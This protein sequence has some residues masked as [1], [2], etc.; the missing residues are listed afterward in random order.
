MPWRKFGVCRGL[1]PAL[2]RHNFKNLGTYSLSGGPEY[3]LV[4]A[5]YFHF[6]LSSLRHFQ[7]PPDRLVKIRLSRA[8]RQGNKLRTDGLIRN[9]F[10]FCE[11]H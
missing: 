6:I 11:F 2:K 5:E 7:R 3:S 8:V 1:L 10:R 9:F 4:D